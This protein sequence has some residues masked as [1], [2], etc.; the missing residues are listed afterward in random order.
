MESKMRSKIFVGIFLVSIIVCTVAFFNKSNSLPFDGLECS[1]NAQPIRQNEESEIKMQTS[2]QNVYEESK[3]IAEIYRD[4]YEDAVN[5]DNLGSLGVIQNIVSRLGEYGYAA[6]DTENQNQIDMVHPELVEQFCRQVDEKQ[7]G[8]VT[9]FSIMESGGFIRF[10]LK[11][12]KGKVYV[13]RSVLNWEGSMP[14]VGYKDSFEAYAWVYSENGYLFFD[15]ALPPGYDG[16]PGYTAIRVKPLDKKCREL[17]RQ[18]ILPI[19]YGS[20]NMFILDWNEDDFDALDFYD[21]FDILYSDVY[22][23]PTPYEKSVEGEV[24]RVPREEFEK[25]IM[26]YF[27]IDSETLQDKTKYSKQDQ[28]YEYRTRG[29]Y[30][31]ACS[32][33]LPYPEV[34]SYKENEDGTIKLTVNV[35]WPEK[36]LDK[37]FCHEVVVRPLSNGSFQYVSNHV[38]PSKKNVEPSWYTEKLTDEEREELDIPVVE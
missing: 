35:V 19:G 11:T 23:R 28:I 9:F 25:V 27:E 33:N 14:K 38:I 1:S 24:Y 17:N 37:V 16:A 6:V 2:D 36:H 20:N 32:P 5:G 3:K 30:D 31:C 21:L 8:E 18:Y 13:T 12:A 7:E 15:E 34:I 22:Q 26:S 29:F 10:D 4:I